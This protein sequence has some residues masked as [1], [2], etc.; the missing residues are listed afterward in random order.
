MTC[1]TCSVACVAV[2]RL[3][4]A[5]LQ[6]EGSS[7]FPPLPVH[8]SAAV[9]S[10]VW[11]L[12]LVICGARGEFVPFEGIRMLNTSFSE[13][14][15]QPVLCLNFLPHLHGTSD[16]SVSSAIWTI[17]C[18]CLNKQ[19]LSGT[20]CSFPLSTK[21]LSCS[22]T[23]SYNFIMWFIRAQLNFTAESL[24]Q[25]VGLVRL[26]NLVSMCELGPMVCIHVLRLYDRS[27]S[28]DKMDNA[29]WT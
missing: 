25:Y 11:P 18:T 20:V 2:L 13:T 1:R 22:L 28:D 29:M 21:C 8:Q 14:N 15:H 6:S 23:H 16:C 7:Y 24:V 26:G 5:W 12:C 17:L 4:G 9:N 10:R 27:I 19:G 3:T